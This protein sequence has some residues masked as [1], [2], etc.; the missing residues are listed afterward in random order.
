MV[1]SVEPSGNRQT[2]HHSWSV[3]GLL[4]MRTTRKTPRCKPAAILR[5]SHLSLTNHSCDG[6]DNPASG[7]RRLAGTVRSR[8]VPP[9]LALLA[10]AV[11]PH[12]THVPMI[13]G[14]GWVFLGCEGGAGL[15]T[16]RSLWRH[17]SLH[18]R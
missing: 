5:G 16:L 2:Q 7:P 13:L 11:P 9:S 12:A 15:T 6:C 3:M 18:D 8:G 17:D 14:T 1:V 10:G 4:S